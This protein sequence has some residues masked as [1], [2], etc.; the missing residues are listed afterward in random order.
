MENNTHDLEELEQVNLKIELIEKDRE[1]ISQH[2]SHQIIAYINELKSLT[3]SLADTSLDNEQTAMIQL[4]NMY[5]NQL[6]RF[7]K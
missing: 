4:I 3:K 7:I 5:A 1:I 2:V 6:K